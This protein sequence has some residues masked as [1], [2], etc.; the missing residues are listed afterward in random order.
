M[1]DSSVAIVTGGAQG[2][3]AAICIELLKKG[4]RVCIADIQE[5]TAKQFAKEQQLTYGKENVMVVSCDVTKQTDYARLFDET[6]A[7]FH[8]VDV[9]VNNAGILTEVELQKML[10]INLLGPIIG[11]QT[12]LQYMGKSN[13]GNGGVVIN[14]ASIAGFLPFPEIPVYVAS[15][16][17]VVGLTRSCGLPFHFKKDEVIFTALCPSFSDTRL[18][19]T[20]NKTLD[21]QLDFSK[22]P[23]L[24]SPEYVAKGAMKLLEDKINGSTLVVTHDGYLYV[25][26]QEK[27][28]NL[29]L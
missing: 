10:D 5:S 27:L 28:K 25:E 14:T 26:I 16:H 22:R 19:D 18:L 1:S 4:Y 2:L 7:A 6:L 3:G 13:G 21:P 17:G 11:C 9:L 15:K 24:L 29:T 23:N 8:R 12:A 20:A